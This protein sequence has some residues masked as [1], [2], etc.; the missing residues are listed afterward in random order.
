MTSCAGLPLASREEGTNKAKGKL[1]QNK[2]PRGIARPALI[3]AQNK[4][5]GFSNI[6]TITVLPRNI[7][8]SQALGSP[9]GPALWRGPRQVGVPQILFFPLP[10]KE[11]G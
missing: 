4:A 11:G 5:I 1:G 8:N 7:K 10:G 2:P 3:Q 9:E 6:E